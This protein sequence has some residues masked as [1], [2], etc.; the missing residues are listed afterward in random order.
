MD[1]SEL[2]RIKKRIPSGWEIVS[3]EEI[4]VLEKTFHFTSYR[5]AVEFVNALAA[6]AEKMDHHPDLIL[7]YNTV[8]VEVTTHSKKAITELDLS[9]V[10]K[11]EE[12]F[13]AL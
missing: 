5:S 13:L 11:T 6:I 12:V 1:P 8:K 3:P 10:E 4:P 2:E 9:F 7:R